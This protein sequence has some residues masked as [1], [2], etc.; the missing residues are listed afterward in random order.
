VWSK[1]AALLSLVT[2]E[3]R[4]PKADRLE[5]I[6][7]VIFAPPIHACADWCGSRYSDADF[8]VTNPNVPLETFLPPDTEFGRTQSFLMARDQ[9]GPI[10]AGVLLVRV[11]PQSIK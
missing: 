1:P 11:A 9:W 10:N 6:L 2:D 7:C 5:W 4:K 8:V 3:L